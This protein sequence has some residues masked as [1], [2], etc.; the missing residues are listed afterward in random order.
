MKLNHVT[1][2]P[3]SSHGLKLST[4]GL[5]LAALFL[6]ACTTSSFGHRDENC[7]PDERLDGLLTAYEEGRSKG[8]NASGNLLVDCERTRNA[9]ERLALEFPSHAR[10][11]MA[12][13][14]LAYDAS[15]P[16]KAQNYLDQVF[17]VQPSHP[18]AGI[19]RSR[20]A[21]DEG[22]LQLAQRV[23]VMQ[24]QYNPDHAGVREALSGVLYMSGDLEGARAAIDAAANLG[25]P[26]WRVA[27][28]RGLVAEAAGQSG[29]AQ[30]QYQ[31]CIDANPSFLAA[32]SRLSGMKSQGG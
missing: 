12:A 13:G 8:V 6:S 5:A 10:T 16:E 28:H 21:V 2:Q 9:I 23:L 17:R 22:N 31:A 1:L 27:Y 7:S 20:I 26:V 25:A 29:E 24:V 14:T 4:I 3:V 18:E 15:E 19:L 11:L 32:K 30:A